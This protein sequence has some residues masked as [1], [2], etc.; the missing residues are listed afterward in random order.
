MVWITEQP[1]DKGVV[2]DSTVLGGGVLVVS[3]GDFS[4]SIMG[5]PVKV[6]V[7]RNWRA[8]AFS[9]VKSLLLLLLNAVDPGRDAT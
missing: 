5:G 4:L 6:C 8:D 7:Q 9:A 2:V 1:N 3:V